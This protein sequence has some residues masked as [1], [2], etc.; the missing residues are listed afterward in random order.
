MKKVSIIIPVYNGEKYLKNAIDSALNQTYSNIEVIVVNDGSTDSTDKI[1]LAYGNRIKYIKKE[2]GGVASALNEGIRNM[3][4][5]Y[6]SW[7]SHDDI[8]LPNKIEKQVVFLKFIKKENVILFA[9]YMHI[10]KNGK[11]LGKSIV[12]DENIIRKKPLYI[13]LKGMI[14]GITLLIPKNAFQECG[15]FDESLRCTQDYALWWKM[16]QKYEFIHM[17][18]IITQT[19]IHS[20]QDTNTN[21]SVIDEGNNLWLKMLNEISDETKVAYEGSLYDFYYEMAKYLLNV[22][23]NLAREY[24]IEKCQTI[25][26]EKY[27]KNPINSNQYNIKKLFYYLKNHGLKAI[28]IR[29]IKKVK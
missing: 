5:D 23:Y 28:M 24:C 17:K 10:D 26:N 14:N 8:Y 13:I 15:Y 21:P 27:R 6:F 9:D 12:L 25:D 2:N 22:P 19:R 4:G 1:C 11:K 20:G 7:L 29:I 18:D 16:I 3:T